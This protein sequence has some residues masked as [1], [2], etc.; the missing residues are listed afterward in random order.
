MGELSEF[1]KFARFFPVEA[2]YTIF[3]VHFARTQSPL[4]H[5]SDPVS[6]PNLNLPTWS[7]LHGAGSEPILVPSQVPYKV[8][9]V[10][11]PHK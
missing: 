3:T 10:Q 2:M 11:P 7:R 1:L 4:G 9:S 6:L 5:R 8:K